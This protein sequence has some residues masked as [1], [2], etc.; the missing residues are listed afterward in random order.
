MNLVD[1]SKFRI[2]K[3]GARKSIP[4]RRVYYSLGE[5]TYSEV[6]GAS[7]CTE[8]W[9]RRS[10]L[11]KPWELYASAENRRGK[12]QFMGYFSSEDLITY[13]TSVNFD[14]SEDDTNFID[15]LRGEIYPFPR[16]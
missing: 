6:P 15:T 12:K 9:I 7:W 14:L 4:R 13:L 10:D 3:S 8:Y 5:H 16:P 1:L 11:I 2:L